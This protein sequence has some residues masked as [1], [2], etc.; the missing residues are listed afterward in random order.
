VRDSDASDG[1]SVGGGQ[2]DPGSA[3]AGGLSGGLV[4][5][6][7]RTPHFVGCWSWEHVENEPVP[8]ESGPEAC[9][10]FSELVWTSE[11]RASYRNCIWEVAEDEAV[12]PV[13]GGETGDCC[14]AITYHYCR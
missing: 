7:V 9:P 3:G 11:F 2:H 6:G 12:A 1:G 10:L 4:D 5:G 8:G 13:P 14:Y